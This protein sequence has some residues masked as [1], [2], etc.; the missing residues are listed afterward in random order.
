MP[1]Y[2]TAT[3]LPYPHLER[4]TAEL[5]AM[6]RAQLAARELADRASLVVTS[7]VQV[8][9]ARGRVWHEYRAGVH[10]R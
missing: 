9:D 1:S 8:P 7:P 5:R 6:Q 10:I 3:A 2:S 4:A